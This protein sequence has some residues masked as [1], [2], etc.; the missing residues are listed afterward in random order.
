[1]TIQSLWSLQELIIPES[2]IKSILDNWW[3]YQL[4]NPVSIFPIKHQNVHQMQYLS[5]MF[6]NS[7]LLW[8]FMMF[9]Q[10]RHLGLGNAFTLSIHVHTS[11]IIFLKICFMWMIFIFF[12]IYYTVDSFICICTMHQLWN[13]I[14]WMIRICVSFLTNNLKSR[15]LT[16]KLVFLICLFLTKENCNMGAWGNIRIWTIARTWW[17]SKGLGQRPDSVL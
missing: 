11:E 12:L 6:F 8:T 3:I 17:F 7:L 4:Q 14:I 16:P 5:I 15:S 9:Y 2:T 10:T 1:M 13:I